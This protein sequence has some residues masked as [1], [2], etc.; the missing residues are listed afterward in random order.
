MSD[1][2]DFYALRVD[3]LPATIFVDLG[4]R[5]EAPIRS[6]PH[7]GYVRVSMARPRQDGL[8]SQDE[9]GDLIAIEDNAIRQIE[10]DAAAI[11]VG[12]NTSAGN[13]DFYFYLAD[14]KR[15]EEAAASAMQR[16]SSYRYT[17]GTRDDPEWQSYFKFL[18]P[19]GP[20]YQRILNRR[21]CDQLE[22]R[23][24][25]PHL[26]RQIDHMIYAPNAAA[27]NAFVGLILAGGFNVIH[28]STAP[29]EDGRYGVEFSRADRPAD[30]DDVV[31]PLFK[32]ITEMGGEY[33]GWG[34]VVADQSS[35]E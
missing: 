22:K 32:S 9:Y 23:G 11:F 6:H 25:N 27:Q 12:R 20:D 24:D 3:D 34:C 26:A 2:W 15:F 28:A 33:D 14:P 1:E 31:I 21:V 17:T 35:A 18:Y 4:I 16:F 10:K 7:M 8:S 5:R 29:D 13:R 30:I 19:S